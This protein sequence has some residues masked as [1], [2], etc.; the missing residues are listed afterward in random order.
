MEKT[1][2]RIEYEPAGPVQPA[3]R[4]VDLDILRGIALF[5]ILVVNLY[6][7][8]NPIAVIVVDGGLWTEWYNRAYLMFSRIFF[9][10]KFITLFSFLFG[11]GFYIFTERLKTRGL[12]VN[13]VFFRRMLLLFVIGML[14]AL[15][16]WAGDV[17][18]AYAIAGIVIML[19]QFSKDKTIKVWIGIFVGGA[20]LLFTLFILLIMLLMGVPDLAGEMM[21]EV[22]ATHE[23]HLAMLAR[24]YDVYATGTFA[25]MMAY[26]WE[27]IAFL[28]TESFLIPVG[29][30][31]ISVLFLLGFLVGRQGLLQNPTLLR[32]L[33]IPRRWKL[34]LPGLL[35]SVLYAVSSH[36]QDSLVPDTW[37][38][39]QF[40][41]GMFGAPLLM[42][43]YTGFILKRLEEN[44]TASFLHRFAPV[45]R[46]ALTNYILQTVICTTLFYGY[47]LGL[48]GRFEPIYILPLAVVIFV[49]QIYV[50]AR[51][52]QKYEMG[53]LEK[54]WR[55]GTYLKRM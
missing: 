11:L 25:E 39:L 23:K 49:I 17:L 41:S 54:L 10:G 37:L 24:G 45:G 34:L 44:N 19:F 31:F 28:W 15:L 55:M 53:P 16:F 2:A 29:I 1:E 9:E 35:L 33:F 48:I 4:I 21:Q 22:T 43:G 30:S 7:F 36:Y 8:S 47:G 18:V 42:L 46:M 26:R 50:S 38:L 6:F 20:L 12:P 5:G 32:S 3:E 13:R 14:H 40:Y 52:I 51:V 27:E